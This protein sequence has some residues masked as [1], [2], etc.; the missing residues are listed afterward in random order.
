ME[1]FV[2]TELTSSSSL[3][4]IQLNLAKPVINHAGH[5]TAGGGDVEN[6]LP[7]VFTDPTFHHASF[8]HHTEVLAEVHRRAAG[9]RR[10][11]ADV[12][13]ASIRE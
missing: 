8:D 11:L 12:H 1:Q 3:P 9:H 13:L 2:K 6:R 5:L 7:P 10:A 4:I